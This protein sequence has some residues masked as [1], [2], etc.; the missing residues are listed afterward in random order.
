M[1]FRRQQPLG[2]F[3]ADFFREQ[4]GLIVEADGP[5]H[6][7]TQIY[8]RKRDAFFRAANLVVLRFDNDEI[9]LHP[10][11]VLVRILRVVAYLRG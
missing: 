10:R 8:D 5:I 1:K 2:P 6:Q 9:L 4:W 11:R 7:R 3:I